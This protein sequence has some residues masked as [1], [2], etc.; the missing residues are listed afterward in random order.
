MT[1]A[2]RGYHNSVLVIH[3]GRHSDSDTGQLFLCASGLFKNRVNLRTELLGKFLRH[4]LQGRER[5]ITVCNLILLIE[6]TIS[7]LGSPYVD[8]QLEFFHIALPFTVFVFYYKN[9]SRRASIGFLRKNRK[10]TDFLAE[11]Q[12]F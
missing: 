7:N 9:A 10:I 2:S 5:L 1:D 6:Q 3:I 8:R 12:V 11:N 4:N